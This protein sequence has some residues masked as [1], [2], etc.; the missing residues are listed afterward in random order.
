M[1]TAKK[2]TTTSTTELIDLQILQVFQQW[3]QLQE[4]LLQLWLHIHGKL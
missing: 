2:A 3:S 1:T 4:P